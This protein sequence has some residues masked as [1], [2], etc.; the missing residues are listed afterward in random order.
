MEILIVGVIIVALMAYASTKIK[1][2]AAEAFE[3]EEIET[4]DFTIIK[5]EGFINPINDNSPLAFEAY[6]KGLGEN[7]AKNFRQAWATLRVISDSDFQTICK[8]AKNSSGKITSKKFI[9]D[10][11]E[12]QKIF[13]L[14]T[15]KIE[16]DV[17][18]YCQ[19]KIVE[20]RA[21]RKIYEL[22]LSV[23][24]DYREDFAEKANEMIESF[25]VK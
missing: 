5:P 19:L 13:L 22:Q 4:D 17:V 8:N 10:A 7:N 18:I 2:S 16:K 23:L 1:K 20:S 15:E 12:D 3:R 6:T 9:E 24:E 25:V 21:R 14:E 11:P